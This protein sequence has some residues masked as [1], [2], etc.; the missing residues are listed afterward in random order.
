MAANGEW[1]EWME[2]LTEEQ[3]EAL[4][5]YDDD[6]EP[7]P[8]SGPPPQ[9]SPS[10]TSESSEEH[11]WQVFGLCMDTGDVQTE[12]V[13]RKKWSILDLNETQQLGMESPEECVERSLF[14]VRNSGFKVWKLWKGIKP[15]LGRKKKCARGRPSMSWD[16]SNAWLAFPEH[17]QRDASGAPIPNTGRTLLVFRRVAADECP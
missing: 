16:I 1:P 12:G 6:G 17:F 3:I 4:V 14:V 7:I 10:L 9:S 11:I 2:D 15:L 5:D 13:P 8:P